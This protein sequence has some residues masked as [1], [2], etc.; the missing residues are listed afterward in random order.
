MQTTA[1]RAFSTTLRTLAWRSFSVSA[2]TA[3][4]VRTVKAAAR[5]RTAEG[6]S[7]VMEKFRVEAEPEVD[8]RQE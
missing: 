8:L 5:P 6:G 3:G 2:K 1:G 4:T 7:I